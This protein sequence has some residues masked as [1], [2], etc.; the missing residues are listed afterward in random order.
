MLAQLQ[1][2]QGFVPVIISIKPLKS[3]P[4]FLGLTH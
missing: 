2:A 3:L 4:E 1:N